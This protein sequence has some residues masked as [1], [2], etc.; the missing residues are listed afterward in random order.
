MTVETRQIDDQLR[1]SE[2]ADDHSTRVDQNQNI[3]FGDKLKEPLVAALIFAVAASGLAL[4]FTW[5]HFSSELSLVRSE[6]ARANNDCQ[7]ANS[8]A[9]QSERQSKIAE[10]K[11]NEM[12]VAYGI[13]NGILA[14]HG[15]PIPPPLSKEKD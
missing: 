3:H 13:V 2:G 10:D 5:M 9:H 6:L 1:K 15:L 14:A 11:L 7:E 4:A 12:R 8:F